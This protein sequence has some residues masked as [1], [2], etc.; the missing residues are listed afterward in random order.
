MYYRETRKRVAVPEYD[1]TLV[2]LTALLLGLGIVMVYSVFD[3]DRG[4]RPRDRLRRRRTTF[5]ATR[6]SCVVGVV[7]AVARVPGAAQRCGSRPRRILF[8][9]GLVLL[10]LVLIPGIGREVNGSRRWISLHF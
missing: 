3:R 4:R 1:R 7:V 6:F 9:V 5:R 8:V 2:W 10:V